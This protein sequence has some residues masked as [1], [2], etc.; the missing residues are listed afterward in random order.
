LIFLVRQKAMKSKIDANA[1]LSPL[2]G[3]NPAGKDL[4]YTATYDEIKEARREKEAFGMGDEG[5]ER[6]RA[7]WNRV[8][9]LC[10]DALR[11][12]TKDLQIAAWLTEALIR[13][14]GFEGF[15]VGLQILNGFLSNFW[16][17]VYPVKEDNDL[18]FRIG[19]LEF[20]NDK[21]S[22][23]IRQIPLTDPKK[24]PGYSLL[25]FEES[26]QV[27]YEKDM[28]NQ[29]GDVS[30]EKKNI[31]AES[32][33]EGKTTAEDFDSAVSKSSSA[34]YETLATSLN[35][36]RTEFTTFSQ[37]IDEKFGSNAPRLSELRE[38]LEAHERLKFLSNYLKK[39]EKAE[40]G[41]AAESEAEKDLAEDKS[42]GKEQE[43]ISE[44][45]ESAVPQSLPG[46]Q[47]SG[48]ESLEKAM[49]QDSL[50]KLKGG[51][52][53]EA[54][55]QLYKTSSSMP[56]LREKSRYKL[57]MAKLCLKAD[58]PDLARPI[59]EELYTLIEELHLAR[60]EAPMWIAEVHEALYQCLSAGAPT[61]EDRLR[62]NEIFKKLCTID[63]TKAMTYRRS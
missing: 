26:R 5:P 25:K 60:W 44:S 11:N 9:S 36:C 22:F 48:F 51:G 42:A 45:A 39:E 55:D 35:V 24:T 47:L 32:I 19:P 7:D 50:K 38:A 54:L 30:E 3:E 62:A 31:R 53:K 34:F 18:E 41:S 29:R 13:I 57:L 40:L 20:M 12:K 37:L 61:D 63:V 43:E 21:L 58:S 16:E 46:H 49:W 33:A 4:R 14:D 8:V 1:L 15:S 17:Q 28:I 27:G 56:S 10:T 59:V 23:S 2:P 6:K 52:I